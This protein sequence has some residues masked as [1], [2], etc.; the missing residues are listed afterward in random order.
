MSLQYN[1]TTLYKGIVQIGE[2]EIGAN[3]GDIS[4]S[5]DKLKEF[6]ADANIA[7]DIYLELALTASGRWQIDDSNQT[8]YPI[9]KTN[10]VAGQR[11]YSFTTDSGGNLILDIYRVAILPSA[12]ATLFEEIKPVDQQSDI[13]V[14][15]MVAEVT[16]RGVPWRYDKTGNGIFLDPIP[17][18]SATSGLKIY[19]NREGSYF[20]YTDTTKKPGFPGIHHRY[21]AI[22][23][24]YEIAR[25]NNL[26][27][28][29][30]LL[31]EVVDYEGDEARGL[32]GKIARYYGKRS[33]DERPVM[34][35]KRIL[36]I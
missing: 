29:D 31:K 3:R 26:S 33:K 10:I 9:V 22:R 27:T 7:V 36:Y 2:K 14:Q 15:N 5:T 12:T 17:S 32:I 20:A 11:D 19:I 30:R 28:C 35:G 34:R 8:D 6:T 21:F 13:D 18:Y 25:R 23:A 24:A 16:T 1:D 4:A